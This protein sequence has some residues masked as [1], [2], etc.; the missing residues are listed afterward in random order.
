MVVQQFHCMMEQPGQNPVDRKVG[1]QANLPDHRG[2][3]MEERQEEGTT[4][5]DME[6]QG[7]MK[8]EEE[9][10]LPLP[11]VTAVMKT[12]NLLVTRRIRLKSLVFFDPTLGL[13]QD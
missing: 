5:L 6:D 7:K 3:G 13:N 1:K 10:T 11:E 12:L 8:M 4:P 9:E 2:M